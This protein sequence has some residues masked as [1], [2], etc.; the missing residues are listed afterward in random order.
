MARLYPLFSGSSGNCYYIGSSEAGILVDAGRSAK[1]IEAR[2]RAAGIQTEAVKAVFIT[3]E[4]SDHVSGLRVFASRYRLPVYASR[5]TLEALCDMEIL[6]GKF[7]CDVVPE[8]GVPCAGMQISPFRIPHDCA[9]GLGYRVVTA[10]GRTVVF[11]TDL[12]HVPESVK[13]GLYG[14]D[15]AVIESNHDVEMLRHGGYPYVLKQRI[16]S[17]LGHLSNA[18]C[19]Q[20]LPALAA[21]GTTRFVLAHLSVENNT[22][23][24]A[25]QT[26]LAALSGAGLRQNL[27]FQL[28]V[29]PRDNAEAKMLIF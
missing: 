7:P 24:A 17:K 11:S 1:Q 20:E 26:A 4:H 23:E 12:G 19:A 6:T 18:A 8:T 22:P 29:A 21:G 10:D 3:H 2:L 16:L 28:M 15:V 27:D 13:T 14:C 9:E 25:Y 5:G